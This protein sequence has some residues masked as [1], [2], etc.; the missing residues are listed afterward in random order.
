MHAIIEPPILYD[1][2]PLADYP[3]RGVFSAPLKQL[4]VFFSRQTVYLSI[5]IRGRKMRGPDTGVQ[6]GYRQRNVG[7]FRQSALQV[8]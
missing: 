4:R 7:H 2:L 6:Q 3:Q 1:E 5:G 8:L